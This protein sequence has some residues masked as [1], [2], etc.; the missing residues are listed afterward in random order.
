MN[1]RYYPV[2]DWSLQL[3]DQSK[4]HSVLKIVELAFQHAVM[5]Y[6]TLLVAKLL[7]QYSYNTKTM[8]Y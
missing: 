7:N 5:L 6:K 3:L 4:A 2:K 1:G 8:N